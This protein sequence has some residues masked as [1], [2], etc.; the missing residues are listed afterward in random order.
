[1]VGFA[2]IPKVVIS[3]GIPGYPDADYTCLVLHM[4]GLGNGYTS[5]QHFPG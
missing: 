1:M 2:L 3:V 4:E 5:L